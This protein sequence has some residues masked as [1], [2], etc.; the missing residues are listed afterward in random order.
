MKVCLDQKTQEMKDSLEAQKSA[1]QAKM[2]SQEQAF[3]EKIR[4]L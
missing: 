3:D 1:Y 2:N 4:S